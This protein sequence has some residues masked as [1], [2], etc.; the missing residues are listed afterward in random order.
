MLTFQ[1]SVESVGAALLCKAAARMGA[2]LLSDS[3]SLAVII[4]LVKSSTWHWFL[5]MHGSPMSCQPTRIVMMW[6]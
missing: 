6:I 4:G 5:W 3:E 1:V 2:F